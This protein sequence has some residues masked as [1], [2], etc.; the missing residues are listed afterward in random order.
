MSRRRDADGSDGWHSPFRDLK[1]LIP[2][3][4]R[5]AP[6]Q[7]PREGSAATSSAKAP[8]EVT[9]G[10]PLSDT[11]LFLT[12]VTGVV[13]MRFEDHG[14]SGSPPPRR[15]LRP[16]DREDAETL[17]VLGDLVSGGTPFDVSDT[18]EH[19]EGMVIGLDPQVLRKLRAGHF[20]SQAHVDLHGMIAEEAKVATRTFL[21]RSLRA[22]HRC[23]LVIHGRG[24][25]SPD[26]RSVLKEGLKT[27]LTRG[28]L[29]RIVLAFS[30]ARACDGG[31]G[32]TYVLLR[33]ERRDR[34]PF[35]TFDGAKL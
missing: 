22:G 21:F 6:P 18:E 20:A 25:N 12:A 29:G 23:V 13:P 28:E 35:K 19:V 7:R 11:E 16:R 30:T 4:A 8:A 5:P 33:R 31:G 17:A 26:Q 27:W 34:K 24:R 14:S 32:A 3:E 2:R 10:A 1:K 15:G 9:V